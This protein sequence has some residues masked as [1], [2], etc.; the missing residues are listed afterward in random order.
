MVN[1][2]TPFQ[3]VPVPYSEGKNATQRDQEDSG[4]SLL[5][6]L[7]SLLTLDLPFLSTHV[8]TWLSMLLSLLQDE[9]LIKTQSRGSGSFWTD[10]H[11]AVARWQHTHR[12]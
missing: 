2:K 1:H 8:S 4:Q 11:M 9:V 3:R 7:L 10:E 6:S 12:E 5:V